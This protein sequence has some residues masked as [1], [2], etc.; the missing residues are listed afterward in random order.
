MSRILRLACTAAFVL[1][2]ALGSALVAQEP[3]PD[4]DGR[5][6]DGSTAGSALGPSDQ[7]SPLRLEVPRV[8]TSNPEA[9]AGEPDPDPLEEEALSE[10]G[11]GTGP[12]A[13][14]TTRADTSAIDPAEAFVNANR[15]YEAAEYDTAVQLYQSVI[16]AGAGNGLAYYNLGNAYL[17]SGQLGLAIGSYRRARALMPRDQDVAA[18]LSFARKSTRTSLAPPSP[19]Q[20]Q[21]TLFFWHYRLS[22]GELL[23]LLVL[24]NLVFWGALALRRRYRASEILRWLSM[25]A[26]ALTL[27]LGTSLA[28]RL[29]NPERVAVVIPQEIQAHSGNDT[30]S[31]VRFKLQA[32]AEVRVVER[33]G[34]WLR[35]ALPSGEQGWIEARH[36]DLVVS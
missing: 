7:D 30:E 5:V 20:F 18:N 19:S 13:P 17:R 8:S 15:A 23:R 25:A 12:P 1:L 35:V 10:A 6:D 34:D 2:T 36:A 16:E 26:L 3:A 33:R 9:Q 29:V 21:S 32:G 24:V 14:A 28:L 27:A 4:A 31:V 22:R 11:R